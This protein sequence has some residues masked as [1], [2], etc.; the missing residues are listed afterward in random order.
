MEIRNLPIKPPDATLYSLAAHIQLV[1]GLWSD[2]TTCWI[3]FRRL[4]DYRLGDIPADLD[5]FCNATA[6]VYGS[7]R[8]VR[9]SATVLPFYRR[10]GSRPGL[11]RSVAR[12]PAPLAV[13]VQREP[14]GLA[15]LSNGYPNIWRWCQDCVATDRHQYGI[16]FWRLAQQLPG[17]SVCT[18]HGR[19]L[20]ELH[21]PFWQRQKRFIHP[22]TI[23]SMLG[24][25]P[26]PGA[27][28]A[29]DQQ[30]RLARLSQSILQD[31]SEPFPLAVL[32]NAILEGLQERGLATHAGCVRTTA[33]VEDMGDQFRSI[34]TLSQLR[35]CLTR[36]SLHRLA[37]ELSGTPRPRPALVNLLLVDWLFGSW[38]L[39]RE[40]CVWRAVLD[41]GELD[42]CGAPDHAGESRRRESVVGPDWWGRSGD[43][44]LR[45]AQ[46]TCCLAFLAQRPAARRTEFWRANQKACRWLIRHDTDWINA[47]LRIARRM[48]KPQMSIFRENPS[49]MMRRN[50]SE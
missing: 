10:L 3:L 35:A 39:F 23:A 27:N 19:T 38:A 6:Q 17:V 45:N 31:T 13:A 12:G 33:F 18:R 48:R 9:R 42:D 2:R 21:V 44:D 46:R 22:D 36:A 49:A 26:S 29:I 41:R 24:A 34:S 4:G 43:T 7:S 40:R 16:T 8:D 5:M 32:H 14:P 47:H 25:V 20:M 50:F 28:V 15:L 37:R 1:N 11:H 30:M